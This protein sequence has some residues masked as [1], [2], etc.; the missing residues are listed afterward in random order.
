MIGKDDRR[1]SIY[2]ANRYNEG[3]HL[4]EKYNGDYEG[5]ECLS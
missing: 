4:R 1:K 2:I 5:S 3:K